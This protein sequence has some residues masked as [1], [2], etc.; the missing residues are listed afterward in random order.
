VPDEGFKSAEDYFNKEQDPMDDP[1]IG[2]LVEISLQG[3]ISF[4]DPDGDNH[5]L[6]LNW[7]RLHN[8]AQ[9]IVDKQLAHLVAIMGNWENKPIKFD[10]GSLMLDNQTIR[11]H[12]NSDHEKDNKKDLVQCQAAL[13]KKLRVELHKRGI[14]KQDDGL[15]KF[16]KTVTNLHNAGAEKENKSMINGIDNDKLP[17][18]QLFNQEG[19]QE[20]RKQW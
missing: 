13:L 3:F 20:G 6:D 1:V 14:I 19:N 11:F 16:R 10:L 15:Y 17:M 8:M 9:P 4:K 7:K 18:K 12:P 2:K 5:R